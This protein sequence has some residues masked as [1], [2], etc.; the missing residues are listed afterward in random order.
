MTWYIKVKAP[1]PPPEKGT[2][3]CHAYVDSRESAVA[4]EI[5][6]VG[7]YQTPF[8][9]ELSPGT[10]TLRAT[11]LWQ[12]QEK[13]VTIRAGETTRVDFRFAALPPLPPEA[14]IAAGVLAGLLIGGLII[15]ALI[16]D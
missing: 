12:T 3:E 11:Y 5:V 8:T 10:Y 13:T 6:G 1:P 9:V 15:P 4:V 2:L 7:T 14:L 16:R